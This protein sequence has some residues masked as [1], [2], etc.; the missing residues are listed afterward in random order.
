MRVA[1]IDI[2]TNSVHLIVAELRPDGSFRVLD[3]HKEMVQL[4]RGE[5]RDRRLAPDAVTRALAALVNFRRIAAGH[6]VTR[7]LAVATSAVREAS[8]GGDFIEEVERQAG[9]RVRVITGEEEGRLI[10]RA[11]RHHV[12]LGERRVV[13]IDIGGGSVE[14]VLGKGKRALVVDSLKLGHIRMAEALDGDPPSAESLAALRAACRKALSG[15]VE[16]YTRLPPELVVGTSGTIETF[17][18]MDLAASRDGGEVH[19]HVVETESVRRLTKRLLKLDAAG[20]RKV[21]GLENRRADTIAAG[22]IVLLEIL[23]QLGAELLTTCTAALREG[24]IL[25][26][27]DRSR[28][29]IQREDSLPDAR[30]RSAHE[31]LHKTSSD[32]AHATH[33]AR[34][35]L[36]L[37]DDLAERH[38]LD[39]DARQILHFAGLLHDIGL[40]VGH[41]RHHK[42]SYYLIVN[43]ALR[44]FTSREIAMIGA[45][46]RYHRNALPRVRHP[47]MAALRKA[48][49]RVVRV[50]AGLLRVADGLDR[51]H[52]QTVEA[53]HCRAAGTR[54]T[55]YVLTWHDAEI[56]LWGAR[57]KIDLFT[58]VFELEPEFRLEKP[59]EG[60]PPASP[61]APSP[62]HDPSDD[63]SPDTAEPSLQAG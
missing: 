4:G 2:G 33:V 56:E 24:L 14:L 46:A 15:V 22:G 9:I 20:R 52:N 47:E 35:A 16:A 34:I 48:D 38:G 41:R 32:L 30:L 8:N 25:D 17:A 49:Q 10:Y 19:L 44:G 59:E 31:L 62:D 63:P 54:A 60:V 3:G 51:G 13:V 28:E 39:G 18:R 26:Y 45:V 5:F 57:R 37:F 1:A 53:V 58:R 61:S 27:L 29:R 55:F 40:D 43:G 23:E 6:E 11:V 42:H 21:A 50:L 36:Q 12:E 7:T